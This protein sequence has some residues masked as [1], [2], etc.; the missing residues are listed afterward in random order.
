MEISTDEQ[1]GLSASEGIRNVSPL[2]ISTDVRHHHDDK[3]NVVIPYPV[4]SEVVTQISSSHV[5]YH[6]CGPD[7]NAGERKLRLEDETIKRKRPF[8]PAGLQNETVQIF[9]DAG[10]DQPRKW[11]RRILEYS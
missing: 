1:Q 11:R 2:N 6:G 7:A 8:R 4:P 5:K 10:L 3:E 9:C